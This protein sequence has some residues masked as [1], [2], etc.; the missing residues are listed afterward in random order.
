MPL[1]VRRLKYLTSSSDYQRRNPLHPLSIG[2]VVVLCV[3]RAAQYI[4]Q[5]VVH[6]PCLRVG[7]AMLDP[8]RHVAIRVVNDSVAAFINP[9]LC[10]SGIAPD[11]RDRLWVSI[12]R[13]QTP[14]SDRSRR[15]WQTQ[16]AG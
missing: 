13:S 14:P 9:Q 8:P 16:Y 5:P 3:L 4:D 2:I 12:Y 1:Q 10:V 15:L 7:D 11:I 6:N